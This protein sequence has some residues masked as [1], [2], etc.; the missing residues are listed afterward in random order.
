MRVRFVAATVARSADENKKKKTQ[1]KKILL[2][3]SKRMSGIFNVR[4][5]ITRH[6]N[7]TTAST[8]SHTQSAT[9]ASGKS[10]RI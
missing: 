1:H 4:Q 2:T 10:G 7:A 6:A 5:K 8:H 9:I 3:I